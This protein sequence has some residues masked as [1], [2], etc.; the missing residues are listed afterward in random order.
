M[1]PAPQILDGFSYPVAYS[2]RPLFG[3]WYQAALDRLE[4]LRR[5]QGQYRP[6][7]WVIPDIFTA[8]VARRTVY[9][10]FQVPCGSWLWGASYIAESILTGQ[11]SVT[12]RETGGPAIPLHTLFSEIATGKTLTN[13][14]GDTTFVPDTDF[15]FPPVMLLA[16]PWLILEPGEMNVEV[17]NN[18]ATDSRMQLVLF[19]AEPKR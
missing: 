13:P 12:I 2:T 6:R 18:S 11:M 4:T 14:F 1:T 5:N 19:F 3:I 10:Q 17:T 16:E 7:W 8:I 9:Y 15:L